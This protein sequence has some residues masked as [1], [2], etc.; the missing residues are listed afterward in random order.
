MEGHQKGDDIGKEGKEV[1]IV[2]WG[3]V[4][5]GRKSHFGI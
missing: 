1:V 5:F 4:I 3:Q 2:F